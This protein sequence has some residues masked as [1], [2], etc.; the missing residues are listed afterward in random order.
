MPI[1]WVPC[2]RALGLGSQFC[3]DVKSAA[4][5]LQVTLVKGRAII[6][7]GQ[8]DAAGRDGIGLPKKVLSQ[9]WWLRE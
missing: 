7:H 8:A 1:S 9:D 3:S 5:G 2:F 6:A 4:R